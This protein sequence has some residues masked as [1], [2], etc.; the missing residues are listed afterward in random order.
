VLAALGYDPVDVDTLSSRTGLDAS[1]LVATLSAL[2]L[3]DR[4]AAL[5]GGRWQRIGP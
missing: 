4:V 3:D 1:T 5:P 2:E